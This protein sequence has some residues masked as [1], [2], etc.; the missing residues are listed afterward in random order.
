M[1]WLVT[2]VFASKAVLE[3]IIDGL[4]QISYKGE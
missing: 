4:A 1:D 3:E 2:D